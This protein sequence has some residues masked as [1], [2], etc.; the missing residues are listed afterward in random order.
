M[1][2]GQINDS[3]GPLTVTLSVL[4]RGLLLAADDG[5]DGHAALA[6]RAYPWAEVTHV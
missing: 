3:D 1:L 4:D 5:G 6:P 2:A